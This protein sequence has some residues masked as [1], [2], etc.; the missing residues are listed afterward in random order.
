MKLSAL[1]IVTM[2]LLILCGNQLLAD[3]S[4]HEAPAD[5]VI[6]SSSNL[7]IVVIDTHG[8]TILDEPKITADMGIID[9]DVGVRNN[10]TDQFNGYKGKIGIE[11][12]GS[13]SQMFPKKQY[14][15]ETRDSV[16][17]SIN[18]S[19]MGLPDESD[20][21]LSAQYNDKSLMR[22]ALTFWLAKA[23]GHYASR[24]RYCELVLN[25]R[26]WGIYIL[27]EKI[28]RNKNRV[29]IT[30]LTAADT[31]G[32]ALTG[33]Y[34]IKI[35]KIEGSDI[36]GWYST[37]PPYPG[38]R[39]KIYYQYDTPKS[40]SITIPQQAYIAS[41]VAA[42]EST[43]T[44]AAYADTV[45]G[46]PHIVDVN[47]FVDISLLGE[48]SKNVDD[49]RLSLFLHKDRD[50]KG[51]KLI[52]GPVWDYN[53]GFGNCDYYDASLIPGY[54]L[55]YLTTNSSF[56][57]YDDNQ[58][59]FWWKKI[60]VDPGFQTRLKS[61]WQ[62]LRMGPFSTASIDTW[63][64]SVATLIDEAQTRNFTKWPIL[65]TYVWPNYYVGNTYQ[66]EL[67][68]LKQWIAARATWLDAQ[69]KTQDVGEINQQSSVV[70]ECILYQN[71]PNPFNPTTAIRFGLSKGGFVSLRVYD[72]L[73]REVSALLH[74]FRSAGQHEVQ[75]DAV[76]L[77]SGVYFCRLNVAFSPTDG[78]FSSAQRLVL[79]R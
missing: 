61:R 25:N 54:Q 21:I 15:F 18:V 67:A 22:D 8:Q 3:V 23:T 45:T 50:S 51:G 30:K 65:G 6:F 69:L 49:Y 17:N 70:R 4:L 77:P 56:M 28:K 72:L 37:Y 32:D 68:Y 19:L 76:G 41:Y 40:S 53:L 52:A 78:I 75:F 33:G 7:P 43:M 34:I 59:P 74:E 79:L 60:F 36:G 16:G 35:D 20:W 64:D 71:Y 13:S 47:S 24:A 9:N 2:F 58:V 55:L 31:T 38:A 57:N 10:L 66:E 29:N 44:T 5:S 48:L 62:Q 63:I 39:Q 1:H 26:Y 11:I 42:F 73:G 14:G 27:F 46:Y 12:R